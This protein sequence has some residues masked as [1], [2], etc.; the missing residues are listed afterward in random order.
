MI[1]LE[2][3]DL[4]CYFG[5]LKAVEK[6][7]TKIK[8]GEL[9]GLIGPNGA[10]KTTVFNVITGIYPPTSGEIFFQGENIGGLPSHKITQ[11]GIVRTFQNIRIYPTLTVLENIIISYHFR[12][13][14]SIL[15]GIL[16]DDNYHQE[17]EEMSKKAMEFLN[18]YYMNPAGS[19][20]YGEQR[21]LEIARALATE[22]NIVLLD[23]P[24]AGMNPYETIKLMELI[25]HIKEK[26]DLTI[27]LI[28]HHMQFVM[29]I[30]ERIMVMDFGIQIAE[31]TPQEIQKNPK[32]IGAYLGE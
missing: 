14:Y 27:F 24:A 1:L 25:K 19:L 18:A 26:F 21:K 28:E 20:P 22:P 8:K 5:G 9:V 29:G 32:V 12:T 6:F 16:R 31:G 3:K 2:L 15:S 10:G 7:N 17:E 23:E 11:K 30:C 13:H 4:C